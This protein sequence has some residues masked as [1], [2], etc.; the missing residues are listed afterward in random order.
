MI[1]I[2]FYPS[3]WAGQRKKQDYMVVITWVITNLLPADKLCIPHSKL[4][5]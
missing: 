2:I 4:F 1:P 3:A 5:T